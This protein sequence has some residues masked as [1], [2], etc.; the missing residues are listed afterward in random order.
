MRRRTFL[1]GFTGTLCALA[2]CTGSSSSG[3]DA[4]RTTSPTEKPARKT[5]QQASATAP[6]SSTHQA[7]TGKTAHQDPAP[8]PLRIIEVTLQGYDPR[9]YPKHDTVRLR[10][11][12]S[13]EINP[14]G[15]TVE[16]DAEHQH[17]LSEF[18]AGV[19]ADILVLSGTSEVEIEQSE[20]PTYVRPACFDDTSI[21]DPQGGEVILRNPSGKVVDKKEYSSTTPETLSESVSASIE[22]DTPQE[23]CPTD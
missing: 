18:Q 10:N 2:G 8:V 3:S 5:D 17:T 7:T 15:Y 22:T 1:T 9:F 21:L 23:K 11:V 20:P 4:D 13:K 6:E 12:A 19:D 14:E 16:F